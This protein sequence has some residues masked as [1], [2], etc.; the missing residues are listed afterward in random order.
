MRTALVFAAFLVSAT[1]Q[2]V[3]FVQFAPA[4]AATTE[5]PTSTALPFGSA[6]ARRVLFAYDGGAV[7][8]QHA[9]RIT[10]VEL[11][12]E[13]GPLGS[14]VNGSYNFTL[15]CSTGR[16]AAAA[17][18]PVFANNHGADRTTV[19]SSAWNVPAPVVGQSPNPFGLRIPFSPP[20]EWDPR[21]GPL[22][23]DFAC[24]ASTPA[25]GSWDALN[26]GVGGISALGA[27][28]ASA[29][30]SSTVAPVLRVTAQ[31][32]CAPASLA[33]VEGPS[34]V[35]GGYL[36]CCSL[37]LRR[38]DLYEPSVLG[39]TQ[40]QMITGLAWRM[41][42]G[43][44]FS[45]GRLD[46][47]IVLSTSSRTAATMSNWF[48]DNEGTDHTVVF[49]GWIDLPPSPANPDVGSFD[50]FLPLQRAFDYDPAR[51]SLVVDIRKRAQPPFPLSTAYDGIA[52]IPGARTLFD[53]SYNAVSGFPGFPVAVLA[54]R[55]V[56]I[57]TAP[58]A[59][60]TAVNTLPSATSLPLNVTQGRA[61]NVIS[62]AEAGIL[63]PIF[64]RHLR[65]RPEPGT[66]FFGPATWTCRID[67]SHAATTPA[68]LS[69][70]FDLNHGS[71]RTR[72]FDG[73]FSVPFTTRATTDPEFPIEVKLQRPFRWDPVASPY[74]AIDFATT[75]LQGSGVA[76]ATTAGMTIDDGRVTANTAAATSGF[77]SNIAFA[78]QLGGTDQNGIATNYGSGCAGINGFPRSTPLGLPTLPNRDLRIGVRNAA[79]NAPTLLTFGFAA[80]AT[81]IA[82][83]PGCEVLHGLELGTY[84]FVVSDA[85]GS[86]ALAL[87]LPGSPALDGVQLRS[88]WFVLDA[89]ANPLGISVSDGTMLVGRFF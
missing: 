45:G 6:L 79:G 13:G 42:N 88:Q 5:G 80:A 76:V 28:A 63:Q 64:I 10:A 41:D 53:G 74:L 44:A 1:A 26:T 2:T 24:Q 25:F 54:L 46:A 30:V 12:P 36:W 3:P 27:A 29:T 67:L 18:D 8:F 16:N 40:R 72:V 73:Q 70:T 71:N 78:V 81:P 39:F 84:G 60:A 33:T 48:A 9:M 77:V 19:F 31:A 4:A 75:A 69:A 23:L 86:A 59:L 20:F 17:L 21:S 87:P 66:T 49:D 58:A 68:T 47:R 37:L 14:A 82:G 15:T 50:V 62:A 83:A 52:S 7:D 55:T 65:L 38:Q 35:N 51:G 61:L 32:Q 85:S 57:P 56:A 43:A 22:L 34:S 89:S 11:R